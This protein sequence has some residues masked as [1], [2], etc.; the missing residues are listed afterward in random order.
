MRQETILSKINQD[1]FRAFA[2]HAGAEADKKAEH[3]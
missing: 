3:K 2:T 1:C